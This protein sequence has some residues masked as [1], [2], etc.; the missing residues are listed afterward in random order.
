MKVARAVQSERG[1]LLEL[2]ARSFLDGGADPD[3]AARVPRALWDE[4][5]LGPLREFLRRPSKGFRARFLELGFVLGGGAPGEHP[6]ELPLLIE[7]LHAGS[8]IVDDIEDGSETRRDGPALHRIYGLPLALNAGNWLYFWP[9]VVLSR[10]GLA[11]SA[12][13][14]AHERLAECLMRCHEGQALDLAIRVDRLAQ[15]EVSSVVHAIARLKSGSL[16]GL[17]T[18]L[19]AIAAGAGGARLDAIGAFGREVGIG[20]QML[21]DLSGIVKLSRRH[22]AVEDLRLA[23]ATWIW[24]WLAEELDAETHDQLRAQLEEVI[25]GTAADALIERIRFRLA[26]HGAHRAR[27][28]LEQAI[29]SLR[30]VVGVGGWEQDARDEL[31]CLER[32]YVGA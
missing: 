20:L 1:T 21:D 24:A 11:D 12:R 18:A 3:P 32:S 31:A 25:A 17:A 6:R 19:G 29:D 26:T 30:A 16:L 4:A 5:L 9:Q 28:Q 15:S 27:G 7:S 13:L 23:R 22:K 2:L 8:L 10:T 14:L